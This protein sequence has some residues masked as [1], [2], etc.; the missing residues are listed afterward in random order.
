MARKHLYLLLT[1]VGFIA[2]YY[3]FISFLLAHG[4]DAQ[5]IIKQLFGTPMSA[6]FAVDL[7]VA[8]VVFMVYLAQEGTR[9]SMKHKWVYWLALLTVGLSFALPLFLYRREDRLES[10]PVK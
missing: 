3:F 7:I 2:P 8:S 4:F 10:S 5:L 6:F 9:W 1:V